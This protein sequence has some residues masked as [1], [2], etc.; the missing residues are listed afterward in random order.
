MHPFAP[1]RPAQFDGVIALWKACDLSRPW[2][3]AG[4]D[5]ADLMAHDAATLLVAAD[6]ATVLATVAVGYDGHRGWI[7]YLATAQT[8]RGQGYGRAGLAAAEAW[9]QKRSVAKVQLMVRESN[10]A[11]IGFYEA[12]GYLDSHV[13]V[14]AKWLDPERDRLYREGTAVT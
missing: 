5:I 1:Y 11:V 10:T 4:Q 9:L 12:A 6:G 7:Y 14:L 3:P 2:N 8:V 13:K